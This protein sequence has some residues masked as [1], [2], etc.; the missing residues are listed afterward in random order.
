[1]L[2]DD[3]FEEAESSLSEIEDDIFRIEGSLKSLLHELR[4]NK[5]YSNSSDAKSIDKLFQSSYQKYLCRC[6]MKQDRD[7]RK[8]FELSL[9]ANE[10]PDFNEFMEF[11]ERR[12]QILNAIGRN[13]PF[14]S[15]H[16][17]AHELMNK[18]KSLFV[19][20]SNFSKSFILY[21]DDSH[22]LHKCD[23]FLN[24]SPQKRYETV[25]ENHLC[26]SCLGFHKV[27][28][29]GRNTTRNS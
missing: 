4:L 23:Q 11:L 9:V 27:G 6:L 3:D 14:K 22:S 25:R 28:S 13:V 5:S 20:S 12:F 1:M 19:K 8:Q 16:S 7:T 10:V 15:K 24:F 26:L 18:T 17:D 21:K 2:P 29:I